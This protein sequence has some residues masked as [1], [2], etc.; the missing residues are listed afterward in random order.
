MSKKPNQKGKASIPTIRESQT[1]QWTSTLVMHKKNFENMTKNPSQLGK[2]KA[3]ISMI[4]GPILVQRKRCRWN[5]FQK[6]HHHG[7]RASIKKDCSYV[8]RSGFRFGREEK[9]HLENHKQNHQCTWMTKKLKLQELDWIP[10]AKKIRMLRQ[11]FQVKKRSS[12]SNMECGAIAQGMPQVDSPYSHKSSRY[13][14][15]KGKSW[16]EQVKPLKRERVGNPNST[17]K[18][19]E[20]LLILAFFETKLHTEKHKRERCKQGK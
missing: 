13:N 3:L 2:K 20:L 11:R 15:P 18:S 1:P 5:L 10:K 9:H 12:L 7:A 6:N 4:C 16:R 14:S 17:R 8:G 19:Q